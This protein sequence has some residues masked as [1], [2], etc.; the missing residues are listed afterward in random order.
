[1]DCVSCGSAG[2]TER[3]DLTAQGYRRFRCRDC[4]KQFNDRSDD[5]LNRTSL[6]SDI[7]AFVVFCRLRYRLTL[8]DLSEIMLLRGF[9]VSYECVRQWEA[10]LLPVMG[11]AL[12]KRRHGAG[13]SSGQ[14]W[15]AD[16]TYLKVQGRWCYLY[17]AIDRDGNLI[18]TMLSATRGMKAAQKFFRSARSVAGFA[19]DRVTT[20]GHNSYPRA[21]RSTLGRDVRH[22][23]NV[24]LNNRLEQDHSGIK[25]RI[26]CMRGFK[27]HGAADRFCR[28]H[29]RVGRR[30]FTASLSQNRT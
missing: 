18:D 28:E 30:N 2:V 21:I 6:P 4:G 24:Y 14:S 13:R 11:E 17:R 29:G 5:V 8:R 3:R 12:R 1:M 20:D 9:A 27:E 15:Y 26:R 7:I 10:K 19:P 22:R 23:T 25:G 16:E